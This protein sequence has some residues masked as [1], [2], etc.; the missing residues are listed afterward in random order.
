MWEALSRLLAP[1]IEGLG[2]ALS[3]LALFLL[4]GIPN[5]LITGVPSLL[6]LAVTVLGLTYAISGLRRRA[7]ARACAAL[8]VATIPLVLFLADKAYWAAEASERRR[9]LAGLQI[10]SM[11]DSRPAVLI[12]H[13]W[14]LAR[15]AADLL[16]RGPFK[17]VWVDLVP[18]ETTQYEWAAS[19]SGCANRGLPSAEAALQCVEKTPAWRPPPGVPNATIELFIDERSTLLPRRPHGMSR[20]RLELR[21]ITA[22]GSQL[23]KYWETGETRTPVFPYLADWWGFVH[24]RPLFQRSDSVGF[25]LSAVK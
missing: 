19:K 15:D 10:G 22:N 12:V 9:A 11:P 16:N 7:Y 6:L 8:L 4:Y 1:I 24:D 23:V 2:Y 3:A 13:G 17:E 14:M 18:R 20:G 21:A 5:F 25:V